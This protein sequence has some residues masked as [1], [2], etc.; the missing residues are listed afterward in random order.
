MYSAGTMQGVSMVQMGGGRQQQNFGPAGMGMAGATGG[1]AG[2]QPRGIPACGALEASGGFGCLGPGAMACNGCS[3][4]DA[5][6]GIMTLVGTG[7]GDYVAETT[8]RYVGNGRGDLEFVD[9]KKSYKSYISYVFGGLGLLFVVSIA[10]VLLWPVPAASTTVVKQVRPQKKV[11]GLT[12]EV[13][14]GRKTCLFWGD[15]HVKT[16]DGARPSFYGDGEFWIVK[17]DQVHIQGRYKGTEYTHGLAATNKLMIGGPFIENHVIEIEPMLGGQGIIKIDGKQVLKHIMFQYDLNGDYG[18]LATIRY[19]ELGDLVDK[20]QS[21]YPRNIL[22]MNMPLGISITVFRWDNYL[23]LQIDMNALEGGQDG[24]CGNYNGDA[25]DDTAAQI[26]ER[27]G[28]RVAPADLLFRHQSDPELSPEMDEMMHA[29]CPAETM[30]HGEEA[31]RSELGA[32]ATDLQIKVCVFDQCFGM[33][34][35][36]LQTAKTFESAPEG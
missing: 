33:N 36:A 16:F 15:P 12:G 7:V 1:F 22:H 21:E 25:S 13:A 35:H 4:A 34:E 30:Q 2:G 29:T 26:F 14:P 20:A 3:A 23:D 11:E 10:A 9:A 19:D 17:S 27:V 28:A 32:S 24:S 6:A 18:G 8:Y 5:G 31:C